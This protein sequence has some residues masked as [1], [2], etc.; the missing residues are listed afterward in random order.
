MKS[1]KK[2]WKTTEPISFSTGKLQSHPWPCCRE[3]LSLCCISVPE[4]TGAM[5]P[6]ISSATTP[7]LEP[8]LALLNTASLSWELEW[9]VLDCT[10][11]QFKQMTNLNPSVSF[12][13]WALKK[14]LE[15]INRQCSSTVT[16]Q[17]QKINFALLTPNQGKSKQR[18]SL[19]SCAQPLAL[20]LRSGFVAYKKHDM[21][22][23]FR[24]RKEKLRIIFSPDFLV[25]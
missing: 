15:N 23:T 2:G 19:L 14:W 24:G 22:F 11:K 16:K 5:E 10:A 12:L 8:E 1:S 18:D 9:A 17:T 21:F 13:L 4:S 25:P 7:Q 6:E 20:G 3:Q